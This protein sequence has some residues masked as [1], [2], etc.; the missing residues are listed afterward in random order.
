MAQWSVS[1]A[2]CEYADCD[3]TR[4]CLEEVHVFAGHLASS[5]IDQ[6][7]FWDAG[8]RSLKQ[9]PLPA[10]TAHIPCCKGLKAL[11]STALQYVAACS[12]E[13]AW[14]PL[15][16]SAPPVLAAASPPWC[17]GSGAFLDAIHA[18]FTSCEFSNATGEARSCSQRPQ[19]ACAGLCRSLFYCL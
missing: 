2:R 5:T 4:A 12:H 18:R 19:C 7:H 9:N 14:R 11:A 3:L 8:H 15:P 1:Q 10:G 13:T 6:H 16:D 17:A